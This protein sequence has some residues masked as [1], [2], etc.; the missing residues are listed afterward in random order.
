MPAR[1]ICVVA[2]LTAGAKPSSAYNPHTLG[3]RRAMLLRMARASKEGALG[4]DVTT[5][6][7]RAYHMLLVAPAFTARSGLVCPGCGY[8]ERARWVQLRLWDSLR[9]AKLSV[10]R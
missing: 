10:P 8:R 9:P 3:E 5:T 1:P 7:K 2:L 6:L 4:E